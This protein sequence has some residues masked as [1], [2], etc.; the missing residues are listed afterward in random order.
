MFTLITFITFALTTSILVHS[1]TKYVKTGDVMKEDRQNKEN[2]QDWWQKTVIYQIYPRS[3]RDSDGD[4]LGDLKG[5][6]AI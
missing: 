4:G 6:T 5:T 3:F 2:G 1:E